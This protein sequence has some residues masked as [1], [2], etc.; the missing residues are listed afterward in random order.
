MDV[1]LDVIN[2]GLNQPTSFASGISE[3]ALVW[4]ATHLFDTS[5]VIAQAYDLDNMAIY[6]DEVQIINTDNIRLTWNTA[7]TG[8]LVII[9]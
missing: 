8:T 7:Q 6:P 1:N 9:Q 4:N 3:A 5:G 2:S